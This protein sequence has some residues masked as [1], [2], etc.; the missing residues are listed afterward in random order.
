MAG[1]ITV[2]RTGS[3][4][5]TMGADIPLAAITVVVVGGTS[6]WGGRGAI[7]RTIVGVLIIAVLGNVLS[8]LSAPTS[9]QQLVSGV[10]VVMAIA[11][12]KRRTGERA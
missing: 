4:F 9:T 10:A 7:W 11:F 8:G 6:I 5:A 12:Q 2:T 3:G 1:M